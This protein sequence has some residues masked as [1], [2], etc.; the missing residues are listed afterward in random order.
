MK[1]WLDIEDVTFNICRSMRQ[2]GELQ[3]ISTISYRD[4]DSSKE[5]IEQIE[6][7]AAVIMNFDSDGIKEYGSLV[8]SVDRGDFQF[9]SKKLE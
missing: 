2:S 6:A 1:F 4:E 7:L 8:G 5:Q 9:K 3:S